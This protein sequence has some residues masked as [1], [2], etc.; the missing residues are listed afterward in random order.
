LNIIFFQ[1]FNYLD[2]IYNMFKSDILIFQNIEMKEKH[3][4]EKKRKLK[5][6][7]H[8]VEDRHEKIIALQLN[9][10]KEIND[11]QERMKRQM[12]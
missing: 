8:I 2:Q 1:F 9:Q 6:V 5:P 10:Q 3:V 4:E 12:Y 11:Y 7:K